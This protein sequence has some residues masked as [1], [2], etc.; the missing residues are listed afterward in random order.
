MNLFRQLNIIHIFSKAK[1]WPSVKQTFY[2]KC[3]QIHFK[4]YCSIQKKK[5]NIKSSIIKVHSNRT[6]LNYFMCHACGSSSVC[7]KIW[8][9]CAWTNWGG[10]TTA[11][12][13][14]LTESSMAYVFTRWAK[15]LQIHREKTSPSRRGI[16]PLQRKSQAA[17]IWLTVQRSQ[18]ATTFDLEKCWNQREGAKKRNE[19]TWTYAKKPS[20][21]SS[22]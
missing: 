15:R 21:P 8:G 2:T 6:N 7:Q 13:S 9:L 4:D 5:C 14:W 19:K 18:W 22:L 10:V 11:V 20:I 1:G 3:A 17:Q 16:K 12:K